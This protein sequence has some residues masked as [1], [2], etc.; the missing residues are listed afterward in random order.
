MK[1]IIAPLLW[2]LAACITVAVLYRLWRGRPVVLHGRFGPRVVRMVVIILVVL[3]VGV[4]RPRAGAAPIVDP[5]TRDKGDELPLMT[6]P[7]VVRWFALQAP[8]SSWMTF[9]QAFVAAQMEAQPAATLSALASQSRNL[10]PRLGALVQADL[11]ALKAGKAAPRV[12]VEDLTAALAEA[13]TVGFFDHWLTAYLWR[14]SAGALEKEH[15]HLADL[16]ARL[17]QNVR[18]TDTL[19]RACAE[20][21]PFLQAPRPWMGKAGPGP[22]HIKLVKAHEKAAS[23][24]LKSARTL[25]ASTDLGTWKRDG[26]VI[27]NV[28]KGSA[29]PVLV[30]GP[31]K[32]NLADGEA[33]RLGR[34]DLIETP[35]GKKVVLQNTWFGEMEL[36]AERVVSAWD[37]PR[38]LPE[39]M[40]KKVRT[41]V[42]KALDGN[43]DAANQLEQALPLAHAIL[44]EELRET[45]K[46][47]GA[48]RMRMILALFDD[49]VMPAVPQGKSSE[50]V[51]DRRGR[52][53]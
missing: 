2:F 17:Q 16:Y 27:L 28:A 11:E 19:I 4:E 10:P 48:P 34:L 24:V 13:E 21:K 47:N 31:R 15:R 12:P 5:K 41:M 40:A 49:A 50:P 14:K 35:A 42:H 29:T 38:Y 6:E 39:E 51:I 7:V 9:K 20:V 53:K 37:L 18:V 30:R 26:Q 1:W 45:P 52:A 3:G 25:Y 23:D 8:K 36:P 46:A 22:E 33:F 43:E 44:R 32:Q